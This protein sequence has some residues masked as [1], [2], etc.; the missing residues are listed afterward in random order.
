MLFEMLDLVVIKVVLMYL[1][2]GRNRKDLFDHCITHHI[3]ISNS[4][5]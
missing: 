1:R 2:A 4:P 3:S 5:D